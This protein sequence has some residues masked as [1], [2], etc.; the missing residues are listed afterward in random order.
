[1]ILKF[2]RT[3]QPIVLFIMP[4]IALILWGS[5]YFAMPHNAIGKPELNT[6]IRFLS[7]LLK[8]LLGENILSYI[9]GFLL[10]LSFLIIQSYLFNGLINKH[11]VFSKFTNLPVIIYLFIAFFLMYPVL[12]SGVIVA[13]TFLLMAINTNYQLYRQ[14]TAKDKAFNI[15]LLIGISILFFL[16]YALL[17][18]A[19]FASITLMKPF[20]WREWVLLLMGVLFIQLMFVFFAFLININIHT[21]YVAELINATPHSVTPA[22]NYLRNSLIY[23]YYLLFFISIFAFIFYLIGIGYTGTRERRMRFCAL[24]LLLTQLLIFT[25][26]VYTQLW[27]LFLPVLIIPFSFLYT[28]LYLNTTYKRFFDL[29]L[30]IAAC[31]FIILRIV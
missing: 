26:S 6:Q 28:H 21:M 3:N 16:P 2:F 18:P 4:L 19:F 7:P 12:F 15:G 1:M 29:L 31:G 17:I 22:Y 5:N 9:H 27:L 8:M 20:N 30:Y 23:I 25:Y 24:W 13:N 14:Y 10:G 11:E